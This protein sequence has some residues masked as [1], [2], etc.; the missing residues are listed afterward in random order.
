[1][2]VSFGVATA[3]LVTAFFLP[4]RYL[5]DPP[6]FIHGIQRAFYVLGGMTLLSTL[7]FGGL[8]RG[9]G[10]VVSHAEPVHGD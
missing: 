2:S 9:D 1:M 6:Q 10:D 7:V 5:S 4:N 3:S 8:K